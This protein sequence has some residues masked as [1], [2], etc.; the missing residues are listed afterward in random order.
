M[1]QLR[2]VKRGDRVAIWKPDGDVRFVRLGGLRGRGRSRS[3]RRGCSSAGRGHRHHRL[4]AA[5]EADTD[6][7]LADV[8]L[9]E[10]VLLHQ[11][12][13]AANPPQVE[14][15]FAIVA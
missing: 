11:F 3:R 8:D 10:V 1:I 6:V 9:A 14:N 15:V 13:E 5:A 4:G 2:T 12:D 7:A